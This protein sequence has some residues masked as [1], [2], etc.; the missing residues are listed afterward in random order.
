VI[1]SRSQSIQL[2]RFLTIASSSTGKRRLIGLSA[3]STDPTA[4]LVGGLIVV[5]ADLL[6]RSLFAPI[7]IPCGVITAAIGVPY[8]LYLMYWSRNT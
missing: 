7:E 8:F 5:L 4:A 3:I 6:G 2:G 1:A